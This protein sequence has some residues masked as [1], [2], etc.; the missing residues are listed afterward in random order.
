M[1]CRGPALRAEFSG[2]R[3]TFRRN[4]FVPFTDIISSRLC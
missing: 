3:G 2:E 1:D 4:D